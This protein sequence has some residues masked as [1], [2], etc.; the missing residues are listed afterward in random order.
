MEFKTAFYILVIKKLPN[1][2][3]E[4]NKTFLYLKKKTSAKFIKKYLR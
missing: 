4:Q 1:T 2:Q 3:K